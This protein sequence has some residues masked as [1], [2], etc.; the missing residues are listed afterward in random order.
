MIRPMDGVR[1][2]EASGA[3]AAVIPEVSFGDGFWTKCRILERSCYVGDEL[4][5]ASRADKVITFRIRKR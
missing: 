5:E 4:V 2:L 3:P 1:V